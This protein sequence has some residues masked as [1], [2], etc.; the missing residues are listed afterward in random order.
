MQSAAWREYYDEMARAAPYDAVVF[1]AGLHDVFHNAAFASEDELVLSG[2]TKAYADGLARMLALLAKLAPSRLFLS[3]ARRG[4]WA[5]PHGD[6]EG[7][8][9]VARVNSAMVRQS[10]QLLARDESDDLGANWTTAIDASPLVF[11]LPAHCAHFAFNSTHVGF[12][13]TANCTVFATCIGR[14]LLACAHIPHTHGSADVIQW[15]PH[16]ECT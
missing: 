3:M 14:L 8:D 12:S 16:V 13:S 11:A 7:L 4:T 1:T 2:A 6:F 9:I 10:N 15:W 5:K